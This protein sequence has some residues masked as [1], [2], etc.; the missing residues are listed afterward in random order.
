V[1]RWWQVFMFCCV[2]VS[3]P[4]QHEKLSREPVYLLALG[5]EIDAAV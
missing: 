5:R 3:G 2:V 4:R 1:V